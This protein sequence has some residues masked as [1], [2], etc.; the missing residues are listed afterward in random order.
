MKYLFHCV[1]AGCLFLSKLAIAQ[2]GAPPRKL[3]A[4]FRI[5]GATEEL[6]KIQ[7]ILPQK[8]GDVVVLLEDGMFGRLYSDKGVLRKKFLRSGSGP[9]EARSAFVAGMIADTIWIYDDELRRYTLLKIDGTLLRSW[10]ESPLS[11]WQDGSAER[12]LQLYARPVALLPKHVAIMQIGAASRLTASGEVTTHP[13]VRTTW[14]SVAGGVIDLQRYVARPMELRTPNSTSYGWPQLF[15]PAPDFGVSPDGAH[16]VITDMKT[17][18]REPFVYVT[19]VSIKGDT[20]LRAKVPFVPDPVTPGTID[21]VVRAVTRR[22]PEVAKLYRA[23]LFLAP[24]WP[25]VLKVLVANDGTTWLQMHST[26]ERKR[27]TV[28]SP[29]GVVTMTVEVPK[30]V[31]LWR[32][33]RGIWG[34]ELDNDDVP[35]VVRYRIG[36]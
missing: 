30:N 21:S 25:P 27:W 23:A 24:H 14:E 9:G 16:V 1:A 11:A 32:I 5:N 10:P 4:D 26:N 8:T 13:I 6:S 33:D 3:V 31:R 36:N 22:R 15:D 34:T 29:T 12:R 18:G 20:V 17:P 2:T 28:V 7:G 19:H 35:S